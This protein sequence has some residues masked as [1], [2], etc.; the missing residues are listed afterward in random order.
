MNNSP[1]FTIITASYNSEKTIAKT[2][3]S[4][5]N[6]DFTDFEYLIIDGNSNDSTLKIIKSFELKFKEKNINYNYISEPDN[7]IYDA[8]NKGIKMSSGE[9]ISFLGS[10]D[11]Y[12]SDALTVYF[13]EIK[14]HPESNYI[15][16]QVNLVNSDGKILQV[17][18]EK[19]NWK[20]V[21]S[22]I[23][24]AQVGSFHKKQL[25]NQVGLYSLDY[26]I[27]GDLDFYIRCK[28]FIRPTYF[29]KVTANMENGG[30][31]N[32][33]YLALKEAFNVKQKYGYKS[34]IFNYYKFYTSLLKC[35]IKMVINKK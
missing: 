27:V 10:D 11:T 17:F 32:Q 23:N 19:Y 35:Y 6:Q 31:S 2:I 28:D 7:G 13:K 26:K 21:I 15:S 25:F 9:W 20:N 24:V 22:D 33:I 14:K 12:F 1:C 30:V 8:W 29:T 34:K 5:L 3:K 4:V 18:G 16:S